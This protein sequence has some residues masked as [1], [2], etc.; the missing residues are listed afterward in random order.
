M[1]VSMP[2]R[3]VLISGGSSGIGAGL[4]RAYHSR[5]AQVIVAGRDPA[6][7]ARTVE[8]RAGMETV[9]MDV[10]SAESVRA[11]ADEVARRFPSLDTLVNNAGIQQLLDFAAERPPRRDEIELEVQTNLIG[12]IHVTSAFLPLLRKQE[13][14]RLVHV[15]SG[16]GFVP[17]AAAPVYSATKAAVHSFTLSLRHQLRGT[18]VR[19]IELIPPVVETDLH[20]GQPRKPPRAMS[21]EAFVAAVMAGLERDQE[22]VAVGLAKVLRAGARVAPSFFR[23]IVN[24]PRPSAIA[25]KAVD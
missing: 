12:L 19:V 16:L 3:T 14:A 13:T 15:G 10:T 25:T 23:G 1:P 2:R 20:R 8:G 4:A 21:L 22:E 17:L 18:R 7:L 11:C 9:R 6:G 5:G 24:K